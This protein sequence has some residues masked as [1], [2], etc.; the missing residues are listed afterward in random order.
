MHCK[1]IVCGFMQRFMATPHNALS[2]G[3]AHFHAIPK[4]PI[5]KWGHCGYI[6]LWVEGSSQKVWCIS[7]FE[8]FAV[9]I[10]L[11]RAYFLNNISFN[12]NISKRYPFKIFLKSDM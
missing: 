5:L 4:A 9:L 1:C 6:I 3:N 2:V 11:D 7:V 12:D 8:G 10:K